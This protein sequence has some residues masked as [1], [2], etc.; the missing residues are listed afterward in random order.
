MQSLF[1]HY[2]EN[3]LS[4]SYDCTF[5]FPLLL[6]KQSTAPHYSNISEQGRKKNNHLK[7]TILNYIML[8]LMK[9]VYGIFYSGRLIESLRGIGRLSYRSPQRKITYTLLMSLKSVK[10]MIYHTANCK[11][12]RVL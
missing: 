5:V 3:S 11:S 9:Y 1:Q 7:Q 2:R 8:T 10:Q 12:T 4:F 6:L